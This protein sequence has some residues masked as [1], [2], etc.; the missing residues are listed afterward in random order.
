MNDEHEN[1]IASYSAL[2]MKHE[3]R[4]SELMTKD[5][6]TKSQA[7]EIEFTS[8]VIKKTKDILKKLKLHKP[9]PKI[10]KEKVKRLAPDKVVSTRYDAKTYWK[11]K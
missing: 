11:D 3:T 1:L 8:F 4:L 7:V 9:K 6:K 10:V 5:R 2:L